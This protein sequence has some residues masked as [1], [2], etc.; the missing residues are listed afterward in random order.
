MDIL[1]WARLIL[2]SPDLQS[3]LIDLKPSADL[4]TWKPYSL[5]DSPAR[6]LAIA[7]SD[8]RI[9]F[10][11]LNKIKTPEGRSIAIHS[12]A[13]HELL[14]IE[15]MAAAILVYPHD[16]ND[17]ASVRLKK[18]LVSTI[19]DE[20]K[21]FKLYTSR[22]R[23]DGKKFGDYPLNDFFWRQMPRLKTMD[24]FLALMS[25]T[26]ESANLDFALQYEDVF[27]KAGDIKTADI[28]KIVSE[29]EITHVAFG[30]H[31]I[32]QWKEDKTLW[33]YYTSILP[34]PLTP[35]RAKGTV[36]A[37]ASR[38][39]AGLDQDWIENLKNYHDDYRITTRRS[40]K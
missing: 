1:T 20:Q 17:P 36:F 37:E 2:E 18:G 21:H 3:K 13:N 16:L 31:W 34:Y 33:E 10:P 28:L 12:F 29:D 11:G 5:P 38:Y 7:F 35:A 26:F 24:S 8:E 40:W 9:K 4:L 15:M 14:A 19:R 27:R 30:A 22:L 32:N 39:E 23:D 6:E 25:M